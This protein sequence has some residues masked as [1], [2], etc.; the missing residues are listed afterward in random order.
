MDC[1]DPMEGG[2]AG[3][4]APGAVRSRSMYGLPGPR[5]PVHGL[6]TS[7]SSLGSLGLDHV[8]LRG[9][10]EVPPLTGLQGL[11]E[12]MGEWGNATVGRAL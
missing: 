4:V 11:R 6:M 9:A 3:G 2:G 7:Q 10:A 12:Q 8:M 1:M 5:S